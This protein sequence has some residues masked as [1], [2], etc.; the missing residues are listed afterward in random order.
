MSGL[1]QAKLRVV[2][3][4]LLL[5]WALPGEINLFQLPDGANAKPKRRGRGQGRGRPR[6]A[7]VQVK[8][9]HMESTGPKPPGGRFCCSLHT[10]QAFWPRC[11]LIRIPLR[12][13]QQASFGA[14]KP[15]ST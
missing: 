9:E 4:G 1:G 10:W 2:V 15:K 12:I 8:Q 7:S 11:K 3:S 5:V 6:K 14:S 13:P